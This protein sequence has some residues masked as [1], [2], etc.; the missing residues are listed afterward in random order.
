MRTLTLDLTMAS[1]TARI[2]AGPLTG[3]APDMMSSASGEYSA[4]TA[5]ESPRLK[6]TSQVCFSSGDTPGLTVPPLQAAINTAAA[7]ALR[8][9]SAGVTAYLRATQG[10]SPPATAQ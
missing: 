3:A 8:T 10:A 4:A 1:I 5:A 7:M 2:A 6:A 9:R